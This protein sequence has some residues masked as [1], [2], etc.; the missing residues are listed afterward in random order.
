MKARV[1]TSI[2]VG[3]LSAGLLVL[4]GSPAIAGD[5]ECRQDSRFGQQFN[6]DRNGNR[7]NN[8]DVNDEDEDEDNDDHDCRRGDN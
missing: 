4:G 6:D 7:G 8:N 3:L 1:R 2:A 5:N